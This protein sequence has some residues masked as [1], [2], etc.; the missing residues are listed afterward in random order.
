M[1]VVNVSKEQITQNA[2]AYV[3]DAKN[4]LMI[5]F[6]KEVF[7]LKNHFQRNLL[8]GEK[9]NIQEGKVITNI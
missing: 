1:Y 3:V 7:I 5:D 2:I 6:M 8:N 4:A 9:K